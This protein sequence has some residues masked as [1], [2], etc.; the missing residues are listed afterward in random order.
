MTGAAAVA[1]QERWLTSPLSSPPKS[2][3]TTV[4]KLLETKKRKLAEIAE[5]KE[6]VDAVR[7]KVLGQVSSNCLQQIKALRPP[8]PTSDQEQNEKATAAQQ[9]QQQ[10]QAAAAA[11]RESAILTEVP[12]LQERAKECVEEMGVRSEQLTARIESFRTTTTAVSNFLKG[13]P[14]KVE[15]AIRQSQR[16]GVEEEKEEKG[17][18]E[19]TTRSKK[20]AA[21]A[22]AATAAVEKKPTP[23][24]APSSALSMLSAH[25][26]QS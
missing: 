9:Q 15:K 17:V 13:T 5:L 14:S 23:P 16:G 12:P 20:G 21:S 25:L 8:P 24:V 4:G 10:Q 18:V 26:G 1:M 6:R 11:M 3:T 22:A 19:R 7:K 2:Y